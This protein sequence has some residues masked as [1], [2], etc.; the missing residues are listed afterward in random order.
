MSAAKD[1]R[2]EKPTSRR[3]AKAREKGQVA[4]SRDASSAAVLLG[5][6]LMLY[7]FG[8]HLLMVLRSEMTELL[9]L[10]IPAD[11]TVTYVS[12]LFHT[13]TLR[14]GFALGPILLAALAMGV[15]ANVMQGGLTFSWQAVGLHFN[16]LSPKNGFD[17]LFSK[18]GFVEL[19]KGLL[20]LF[21]VSVISY[22]VVMKYLPLYPRLVLMDVRQ[23]FYWTATISYE[24]FLRVAILL[25][26]LALGDYAFQKYRYLEQLKMTKQEVKDEH[27]DL[28]GDT[29]TRSRIRRLQRE[30]SRKRMMAD[31]PTADV[32]VTNPTHYA[33]ALSYKMDSMDAP[34]VVAK[35]VGFWHSR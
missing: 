28:E 16:K 34:R 18:N 1:N 3:L 24:V 21:I 4:R 2:T 30:M 22:R 12:S 11:V 19:I 27:K 31:V 32:V 17:R 8:E 35:G 33:V 25:L 15:S 23:L 10:R 13:V 7:Y 6:L 14:V 20:L 5:V 26:V 9:S 29:L